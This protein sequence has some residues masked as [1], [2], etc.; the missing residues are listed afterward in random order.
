MAKRNRRL[1]EQFH[2]KGLIFWT[3]RLS[4]NTNSDPEK[5]QILVE[6]RFSWGQAQPVSA[7]QG[8]TP[9]PPP[10]DFVGDTVQ[11]K[12]V[13]SPQMSKKSSPLKLSKEIENPFFSMEG[14]KRALRYELVVS[15]PN[16][17]MGLSKSQPFSFSTSPLLFLPFKASFSH[18]GAFGGDRHVTVFSARNDKKREKW[19]D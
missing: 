9:V 10:V 8:A 3:H 15:H 6:L 19:A 16:A 1:K 7:S 2:F 18:H 13:N 12:E 11:W 4:I 14:S 17:K 5:L